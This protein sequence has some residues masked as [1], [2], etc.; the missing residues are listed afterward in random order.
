MLLAHRLVELLWRVL[1]LL[2]AALPVGRPLQ[3][4][5]VVLTAAAGG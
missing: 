5:G 3:V 4:V 2:A 1:L